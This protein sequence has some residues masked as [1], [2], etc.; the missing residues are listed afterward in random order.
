MNDISDIGA[1]RT[2]VGQLYKR[3]ICDVV[4]SPGSRNAPFILSFNAIEGFQCTSVLDERSAGFV[5]LGIAQQKGNPAVLSCTSG[6]AVVN[7]APALVEAYY[8][9]IPLIA[10]TAD[11]PAAWIDQGEG[12]SIRQVGLLE[13]VVVASFNLVEEHNE[14]DQ[15]H[16]HRLVNEALETALHSSRPV[17]INVPLSEPLYGT[18]PFDLDGIPSF[19]F[20]QMKH[21]VVDTELDVLL[22]E[23]NEAKSIAILAT[24][25]SAGDQIQ[26]VLRKIHDDPRVVIITET[27]ANVYHLG[28]VSCIDRTI[29]CFIGTESEAQYIPEL[30]ITVGG[31][32]ISKKLKAMFRRHKRSIVNHWHFGAEV[33]DTFQALTHLIDA[34]PQ[35]VLGRCEPV[36]SATGE[37]FGVRWKARFFEV[38]QKHL[39]F[40]ERADYSDLKVFERILDYLPD[41]S[42]LQMGNSS[43]VRYIQLFNQIRGVRYFGNRGVSGIEGCT[44][45]SVGAA[46]GTDALTVLVSGDQAFRYDANALGVNEGRDNLRVIVINN[47][48]GNIFRIIDGPS[49][50]KASEAFI[51]KKDES[52]IERLV[53]YHGVDYLSA[54]NLEELD[55]SLEKLFAPHRKSSAVLEVFTPRIESPE[56]LKKYFSALK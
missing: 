4:L 7:Y 2:L 38:E 6:S 41:G 34:T 18:A 40:L 22:N 26:E 35:A 37:G 15:W 28:Y 42:V 14:L 54:K 24:D 1:V 45:T 53:E 19:S 31:N 56:I 47:G 44:S 21:A 52:S 13:N 33:M 51:E 32:V 48:G 50:H 39:A 55:A 16:N 25:G 27:N 36:Y 11:R 30:L 9:K 43:V 46:L 3:S 5:A 17:Q 29:E 10:I 8:Q 12:Q 20:A 23:W 49:N